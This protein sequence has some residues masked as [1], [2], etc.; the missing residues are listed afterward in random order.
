SV[1]ELRLK[2]EQAEAQRLQPHHIQ[3]FFV[4][5]FKHLGGQIRTREE[6]RWEVLHVPTAIR[7]RD[8]QI[9]KSTPVQK[10]YER[11]C[12]D[13]TLINQQPVAAFVSPGHPLLEC[14][15]SLIRE[16]HGHLMRQGAV[17]VDDTDD[18]TDLTPL[19]LL[20]HSVQDGRQNSTGKSHIISEKLQFAAIHAD[21]TVTNAGIAP[22][23]NL[24][25][26]TPDEMQEI[27]SVLSADWLTGDLEKTV[28]QFAAVEMAQTHLSE[29]KA[30]RLPEIDKVETEVKARLK[31][32]INHWD[33]RAFELKEEER[34]GKK[35][36]LNWQ[37]A[38]RRAE[39]LAER[40]QRR[41]QVLEQERFISSQP[42]QVRG[43]MLVVP[44]G[45]LVK[46]QDGSVASG[47]SADPEARRKIELAAMDA[48][49][50][51]ER[52]L[53]NSPSDVSAQKIGYD[54]AS[55]DP[56]KDRLRFI[57]VKGRIAGA[58]TVMLTRQ[59]VITSLHEPEKFILA[60]VEVTDGFAGEPRY[61]C[62]SLDTR[63]PPFEQN[64]IQF[65]LK[66]LLE[67]AEAPR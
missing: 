50:V 23:L 53:G 26:I 55:Y 25:P 46:H 27:E 1:H 65:N 41:M 67:R 17:L 33:S 62:G 22:H 2:I 15:I 24:R 49:M 45:L 37:N 31:K 21:G 14:V 9:G 39:D 34:A 36:R 61:L 43:G 42:P 51:V 52:S 8:R 35:T 32:E 30:R 5:A 29:V 19:F 38:Q 3:S 48:V 56:N 59:E 63:E 57:E 11:V 7:E 54:I 66:R 44:S 10:K 20:Q 18:G 40:L 60:L 58:D 47:F 4:E 6:G 16:K 12:F 13:K 28:V 64:A